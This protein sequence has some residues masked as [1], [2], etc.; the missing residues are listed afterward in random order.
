M[1][2]FG[3]NGL[4]IRHSGML[5]GFLILI[6][7]ENHIFIRPDWRSRWLAFFTKKIEA[8]AIVLEVC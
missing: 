1:R 8:F 2:D 4:Y 5:K 7:P 3:T 6:N